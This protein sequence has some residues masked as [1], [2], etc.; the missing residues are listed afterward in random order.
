MVRPACSATKAGKE[1]WIFFYT[2]P[3]GVKQSRQPV[4]EDADQT[5]LIPRLICVFVI[6]ISATSRENLSSGFATR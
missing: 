5:G 3:L 1:S 2:A 6:P 4:T